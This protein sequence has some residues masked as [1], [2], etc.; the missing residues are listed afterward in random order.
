MSSRINDSR[1]STH[2]YAEEWMYHIKFPPDVNTECLICHY[3]LDSKY[4]RYGKLSD[5]STS[6]ISSIPSPNNCRHN[7]RANRDC[8]SCLRS[9]FPLQ[10]LVA[11]SSTPSTTRL[12]VRISIQ[13]NFGR[14]WLFRHW[15]VEWSLLNG[16]T[17]KELQQ[18]LHGKTKPRTRKSNC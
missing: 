11:N 1:A 2:I 14:E 16:I 4:N 13:R 10:D 5:S 15:L 12:G 9:I 17:F 8:P 7:L 6:H 18:S 3:M